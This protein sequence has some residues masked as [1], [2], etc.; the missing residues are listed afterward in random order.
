[1]F[2]KNEPENREG[3]NLPGKME[4]GLDCMIVA[5]MGDVLGAPYEKVRGAILPENPDPLAGRPCIVRRNRFGGGV[6]RGVPRLWTDD[7]EMMVA[8]ARA[9]VDDCI[10]ENVGLRRDLLIQEYQTWAN[11]GK[12]PFMGKNTRDHFKGVTTIRGYEAR[13]KKMA[14]RDENLQGNGPLMRAPAFALI[15]WKYPLEEVLAMA[16]IDCRL[17]NRNAISVKCVQIYVTMLYHLV[18]GRMIDPLELD[19]S[20][21]IRQAI[22]ADEPPVTTGKNS[23]HIVLTLKVA[24]WKYRRI[25][26]SEKTPSVKE[27]LAEVIRLGGDTDTNSCVLGGLLGRLVMLKGGDWPLEFFDEIRAVNPSQGDIPLSNYY[28]PNA[29]F[30]LCEDHF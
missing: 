10:V 23:G 17:T 2:G 18:K 24:L 11:E 1:M 21:E 9:L 29:L 28:S 30:E 25:L 15:C 20:E 14:D 6:R 13:V 26:L 7:T 22:L 12:C 3:G 19:L 16:E 8:L 5:I 27:E 4:L